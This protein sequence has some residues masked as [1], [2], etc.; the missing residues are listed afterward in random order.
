MA[1]QTCYPKRVCNLELEYTLEVAA[2]NVAIDP[3]DTEESKAV[4][5]Q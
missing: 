2:C 1:F 4:V 3:A 5:M